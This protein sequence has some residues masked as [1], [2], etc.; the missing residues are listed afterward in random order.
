MRGFQQE[1]GRDYDE[2]FAPIAHMT[3]VRILLAFASMRQWSI[4]QLD[5]KNCKRRST[6][7]H[8]RG[9]LFLLA[10]FASCVDLFTTSS[11]LLGPGLSTSP[12]LSVMLAGDDSQFIDFVKIRLSNKFSMSDL[13]SSLLS[14][15][16]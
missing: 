4:F 6:C 8:L 12:L 14:W 13:S 9:I 5:V 2:T 11:T 10:W 1:R 3:I 15:S 7:I 16:L